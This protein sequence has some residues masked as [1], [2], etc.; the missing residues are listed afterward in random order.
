MKKCTN[1]LN[2]FKLYKQSFGRYNKPNEKVSFHSNPKE[3]QCQKIFKLLHNCAHFTCKQGY[4]LN[5][6][7]LASALCEREL[8]GVKP[9]FRKG[10]G[11]REQIANIHWFIE[12]RRELQKNI[13]FCFIDYVKAFDCGSQKTGKFF[14]RRKHQAALLVL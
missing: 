12:N 1:K 7:S 13:Y 3:R 10:R 8:P 14:K 11:T 2:P 5:P 4:A 9:A 6:S